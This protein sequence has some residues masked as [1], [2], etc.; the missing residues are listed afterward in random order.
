MTAFRRAG[1][2][3][4]RF[5]FTPRPTSTLGVFR[6]AFGLIAIGWTASLGPNLFAFFGAQGVLP[7]HPPSPGKWS[8]V[9]ADSGRPIVLLLYAATALGAVALTVGWHSRIAAWMVF[10]GVLSF[11]RCNPMIINAGDGLIR[12]LALYCALSPCGVALSLDRRRAAPGR[13]WEFPARAP[14]AL[15]L[16]QIQLSVV[17]LSTVWHK[18]QGDQWRAG[19]AVSYALRMDDIHRFATP[20]F[21]T[22]SVVLTEVLTFGT[23]ALEASLAVLVWNRTARPWIL[24]MGVTLHLGIDYSIMVGFFSYTMLTAYLAFTPPD[25]ATRWLLAARRYLL[26]HA[27]GIDPPKPIST[28]N[29]RS[30]PAPAME[31][32]LR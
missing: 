12:N 1:E 23:L 28:E 3:W 24:A 32:S 6:I 15:R 16:V 8:L 17:Y 29:G 4:V 19:T 31:R 10:V 5:W 22:G 21:V 27:R 30:T 26:H 2:G 18:V 7:A 9:P 13:F 20:A 14:W 11:Q 25:T